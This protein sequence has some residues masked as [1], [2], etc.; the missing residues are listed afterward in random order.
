MA[1]VDECRQAL[2]DLAARLDANAETRG[3]LDLDR[4][5]ACRVPDLSTAFH[6]RLTGGRLVDI[7]DGDDPGAKIAL[8]AASDDLIAL[9]TGR[10]DVTRAIAARQVSVKANPFDLL[11]LRKL[12]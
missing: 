11:K 10:L 12:L 8:T 2:H 5:L 1:S 3:K 6:G 9:V 7:A 4:T